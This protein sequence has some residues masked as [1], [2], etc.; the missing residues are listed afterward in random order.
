MLNQSGITVGIELAVRLVPRVDGLLAGQSS[1][2]M[3]KPDFSQ[4]RRLYEFPQIRVI[5]DNNAHP[6]ADE[7]GSAED[8]SIP[9]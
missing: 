7:S 2:W 1:A 4:E 5:P 6:F 9:R 3:L 8:D